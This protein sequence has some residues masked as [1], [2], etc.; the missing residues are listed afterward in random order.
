[1]LLTGWS[2]RRATHAKCR[3]SQATGRNSQR[4]CHTGKCNE[5]ETV[6]NREMQGSDQIVGS[7]GCQLTLVI[8]VIKVLVSRESQ[9]KWAP[10]E[11]RRLW[12]TTVTGLVIGADEGILR[13]CAEGIGDLWAQLSWCSLL[14]HL[15]LALQD[16]QK[17]APDRKRR[18]KSGTE[19]CHVR[20][21][22]TLPL[23]FVEEKDSG[24][25]IKATKKLTTIH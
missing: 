4:H 8:S 13:G 2:E 25:A 12:C 19:Q 3:Q 21:H 20:W 16:R 5:P 14:R 23:L 11:G 10:T 15:P 7:S 18:N 9:A 17:M 1:M 24:G 22:F 6:S